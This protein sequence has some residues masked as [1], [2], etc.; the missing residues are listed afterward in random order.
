M[1]GLET[2]PEGV[3]FAP[4]ALNSARERE[5]EMVNEFHEG[6]VMIEALF[7]GNRFSMIEENPKTAKNVSS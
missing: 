4:F 3:G 5:R 7:H 6:W 2:V 1:R